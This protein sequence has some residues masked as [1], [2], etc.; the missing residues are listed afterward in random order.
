MTGMD[1][2]PEKERRKMR[3]KYRKERDYPRRLKGIKKKVQWIDDNDD[4][5]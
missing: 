2:V 3:R 1:R 5:E 4:N